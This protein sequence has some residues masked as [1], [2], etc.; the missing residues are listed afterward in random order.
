MN[1]NVANSRN[2]WNFFRDCDI[3][4]IVINVYRGLP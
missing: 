2:E 4:I 1:E 3:I